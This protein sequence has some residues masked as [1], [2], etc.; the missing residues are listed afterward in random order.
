MDSDNQAPHLPHVEASVSSALPPTKSQAVMANRQKPLPKVVVPADLCQFFCDAAHPRGASGI[1]SKLRFRQWTATHSMY[2]VHPLMHELVRQTDWRVV[3]WCADGP[4]DKRDVD[5]ET[6]IADEYGLYLIEKDGLNTALITDS[7]GNYKLD[8]TLFAAVHFTDGCKKVTAD[9]KWLMRVHD[10]KQCAT[11]AG[12]RW[13]FWYYDRATDKFVR[14][15]QDDILLTEEG[16]KGAQRVVDYII[17]RLEHEDK[18]EQE[19]D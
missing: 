16:G 5:L 1:Q 19:P 14:T 13:S 2:Y 4:D 8:G 18:K 12:G 11:V 3:V 10:I 15:M 9:L 7:E 17:D 6:G